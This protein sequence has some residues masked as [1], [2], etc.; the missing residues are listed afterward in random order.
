MKDVFQCFLLL[1]AAAELCDDDILLSG[2]PCTRIQKFIVLLC[3]DRRVKVTLREQLCD[4]LSL[5]KVFIQR[6]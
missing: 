5:L 2:K 4:L 3:V 1:A 6:L